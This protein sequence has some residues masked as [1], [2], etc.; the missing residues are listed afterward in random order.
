MEQEKDS[1]LSA[2]QREL[3]EIYHPA[4]AASL[5]TLKDFC[6]DYFSIVEEFGLGNLWQR[7]SL[8]AREK[9]LVVFSTLITQ[10]DT[11]L[12]LR[13][14]VHTALKRGMKFEEILESIILLAVYI[15]VPRTLNAIQVVRSELAEVA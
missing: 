15:G 8:T 10:G 13:Q 1:F 6:P 2:G 12:Q 3:N 11:E 14:H 7:P 4:H 5:R 9:E